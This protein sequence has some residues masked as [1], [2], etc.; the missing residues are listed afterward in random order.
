MSVIGE[1]KELYIKRPTALQ[2]DAFRRRLRILLTAMLAGLFLLLA[3]TWHLQVIQGDYFL[4][5]SE[6][7]RL[8]SLRTKSLRGKILDRHGRVLADNRAAYTLMAVPEDLPPPAQLQSLLLELDIEADLKA[9][10]LSR[11]STVFKPMP[12]QRDVSRNRVAYF[13]EHR[14]DFPGLFIEAEPLRFYPHGSLAAHLIGYLGEISELQL[15]RTQD[16]SYQPGELIGQY[17]LEQA[18]ESV[19]R[20]QHGARQVEVDAF[21]REIQLI[22]ARPQKPGANL[23]LTMD[24]HLQQ[25]AE[26]LLE[27]HTGSIIALDP[28]N[29]QV[30]AL[31]SSPAFDPNRFA[32]R[33]S[34]AEWTALI[35][36]ARHPLHNRALQGQYPPGSIFK[37]VTA[38][39]ALEEGIITPLTTEFCPGYYVF[40][41]RTYRDWK[42]SGHGFVN[43]RKALSQSC[44]VYF[45]RVGQELGVDRIARY[46]QA[47]GLG[48]PS[49]FAPEIEK[50]GL[51][52]STHWKRRARGQPW[53]SG[54]TLSVAIGQSYTLFTPLQAANMIAT[55]A[56]G[57]TLYKPYVLLRHERADG[58]V[59]LENAPTVIRKL[60]LTPQHVNVVRQGLWSVVHDANGTGKKARHEHIAIAGKTGT[61]QVIRLQERNGARHQQEQL[62]EYQRDHA[63]FVAFAPFEAPRIAVVVMI[64]HAGKGGSHFATYAKT[65]IQAYLQ[66]YPVAAG[67][68]HTATSTP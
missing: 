60:P 50:S 34:E 4:R 58:T 12:V 22:A 35:T 18:Y 36:N 41:R 59:L 61:A 27:A 38:L 8:R 17:G 62:P 14:M 52:P 23:V 19:L 40:G 5:L 64:E 33:L 37:I 49:G 47:F 21:G 53:Y 13:A 26:E 28:R 30:L 48:Q 55:L 68:T 25:L 39:A 46:G 11:S 6:N 57:G 24:L 9:L 20:G 10:H 15:Q 51:M 65:L 42:P 66:R 1:P 54:E 63:W 43:L 32:A 16:R 67:P 3:R 44:D 29:G 45:Y 2:D 7:N 56:N 31:A